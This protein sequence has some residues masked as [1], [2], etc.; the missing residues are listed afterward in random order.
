[1]SKLG[2]DLLFGFIYI[3]VV[4]AVCASV[5]YLLGAPTWVIASYAAVFPVFYGAV[6]FVLFDA[7]DFR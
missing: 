2:R 4:A 5:F 3:K 1:M 7:A 6:V